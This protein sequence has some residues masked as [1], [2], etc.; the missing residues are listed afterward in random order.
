MDVSLQL[1]LFLGGCEE[2]ARA[3]AYRSVATRPPSPR[4]QCAGLP[5]AV[6]ARLCRDQSP[7]A[8]FSLGELAPRR[9]MIDNREAFALSSYDTVMARL[10]S[11]TKPDRC[12]SQ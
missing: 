10:L 2:T 7:L 6:S 1:G 4:S 12:S 11:T 3:R 9:S 5:G 8:L